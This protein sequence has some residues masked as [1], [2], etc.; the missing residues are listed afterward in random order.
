MKKL[1]HNISEENTVKILNSDFK[2]G[3]KKEEVLKRKLC[4]QKKKKTKYL[5]LKQFKRPLMYVLM[6]ASALYFFSGEY[7]SLSVVIFTIL[8]YSL[9]YYSKEKRVLN[10][11][12]EKTKVCVLRDGR[13]KEVLKDELVIGDIV[14]LREGDVIP[15]PVSYTHLKNC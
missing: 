10:A 5:F 12:E 7:N 9:F 3:L 1:Y 13:E 6:F 14:C 11:F 2:M 8:F 4:F 15:R